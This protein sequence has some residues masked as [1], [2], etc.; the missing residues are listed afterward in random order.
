[1]FMRGRRLDR[2]SPREV[3]ALLDGELSLDEARRRM[4][5]RTRAYVRRQ[6]TWMRKLPDAARIPVSARSADDVADDL[7]LIEE[8]G[9]S[10]QPPSPAGC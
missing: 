5:A 2:V 7:A 1:M 10:V 6:L 3:C 8:A 9:L 4:Q